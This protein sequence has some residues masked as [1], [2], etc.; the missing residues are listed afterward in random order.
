MVCLC[1][2][3]CAGDKDAVVSVTEV[4]RRGIFLSVSSPWGPVLV[5][6]ATRFH[7]RI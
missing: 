5:S 6:V 4:V 2:P 1:D 7:G 3:R